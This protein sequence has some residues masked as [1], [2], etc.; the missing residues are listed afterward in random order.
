MPMPACPRARWQPRSWTAGARTTPR[1]PRPCTTGFWTWSASATHAPPNPSPYTHPS[2]HPNPHPIPPA[3]PPCD[4]NGGRWTGHALRSHG[5]KPPLP[6]PR[7]AHHD[8]ATTDPL[9]RKSTPLNSSHTLISYADFCL[10]KK[11]KND[12]STQTNDQR[13]RL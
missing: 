3:C 5:H 7:Q 2:P 10:K 9:D 12:K 4:A 8:Q 6:A 1:P 11:K 13:T